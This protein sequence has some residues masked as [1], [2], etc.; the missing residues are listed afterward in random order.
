MKSRLPLL[1]AVF[2]FSF[3]CLNGCS[4]RPTDPRG[5]LVG[6]YRLHWGSSSNCSGRRIE[7]STLELRPDGTSEQRD[8]FKDGSE[9][10]TEGKWQYDGEDG[11]LLDSLR[12]TN[13]LEIDKNASATHAGLIVQ[14]SNPPNIL[15]NPDDDCVFVKAQS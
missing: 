7:T 3:V 4:H 5:A 12:A 14:W 15:L 10:V 13:T 6:Q 9:F 8:R 11:V 1:T 2:S